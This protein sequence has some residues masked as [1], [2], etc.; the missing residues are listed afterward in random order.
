MRLGRRTF[1]NCAYRQQRLLTRR[2]LIVTDL[3]AS[4]NTLMPLNYL[5]P[6]FVREGRSRKRYKAGYMT[7][8]GQVTVAAVYDHAYPF[9]NGLGS[10]QQGQ[11]WGAVNERGEL[12]I[13]PFSSTP[14]EFTEGLAE[15][16]DRRARF[17]LI[18]TTGAI[19]G[20]PIWDSISPFSGGL[21]C[22]RKGELYGYIDRSG[23]VV[24]PP[25]F[26]EA[27]GF[28]EGLAAVRLNDK[29]GYIKPDGKTAIANQ[30]ICKRGMAG[31]FRESLARVALND[32][33]GYINQVG[34]FVIEPT[35]DMALEFSEGYGTVEL[36]KRQGFVNRGGE[37]VIPATFLWAQ[38][39]SEGLA[40]VDN[41]DGQAHKS[42]K[43]ASRKGF[44][45]HDGSFPFQPRFFG[46]GRFQH[47]LALV[48]TEK[49]LSYIDKGGDVVWS[50]GYVDIGF[51][52][53]SHL[54][55]QEG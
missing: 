25:F 30:F 8:T 32:R 39:F 9:R 17:G 22:V 55:P 2:R 43:D 54:L 4:L 23:C 14:L 11:K 10:V 1:A 34:E 45:R 47:G 26:E 51:L 28:S 7:R 13:V 20:P 50:S 37:L 41:G 29:W 33:W 18:D 31:P 48:E 35:F 12:I 46:V 49:E 42:I 44:I 21:A 36:S 38:R 3:A 52:D 53:P 5:F 19:V 24:I 40:A 16:S 27:R 15:F 6:I